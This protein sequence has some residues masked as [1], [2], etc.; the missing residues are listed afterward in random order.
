LEFS[1]YPW[2]PA[3][4]AK[5]LRRG[6]GPARSAVC[7]KEPSGSFGA[8]ARALLPCLDLNMDRNELKHLGAWL[9]IPLM[10]V[11]NGGLRDLAYAKW[12]SQTLAHS[13][14][15]LPLIAAILLWSRFLARRW[16]LADLRAGLRVGLVWLLLTLL[17]EFGLGALRGVDLSVMLEQ[18][19]ITRGHW[20]PLVPLSMGVFP[21][22]I[23][24][25]TVRPTSRAYAP[26]A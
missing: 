26:H 18:Y 4:D 2:L 11:I 13:L 23:R 17:F 5:I 25:W 21:E 19:D 9:P 15:V 24:R 10:A 7:Q 12:M 14:S 8:L 22:L 20:W 1:N 3:L 16:P 6:A